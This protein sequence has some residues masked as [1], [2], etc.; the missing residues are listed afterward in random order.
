MYF[1]L[2]LKF[3]ISYYYL[4]WTSVLW[5]LPDSF[6]PMV[7]TLLSLCFILVHVQFRLKTPCLTVRHPKISSFWGI[8]PLNSFVGNVH[9]PLSW[10]KTSTHFDTT[11]FSSSPPSPAMTLPPYLSP[12]LFS[13]PTTLNLPRDSSDFWPHFYHTRPPI[14]T[15]RPFSALLVP[16]IYKST[17]SNSLHNG[18]KDTWSEILVT[19]SIRIES[20]KKGNWRIMSNHKTLDVDSLQLEN[21]CIGKEG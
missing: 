15:S 8:P 13:F 5:L 6:I 11:L 9:L 1:W 2:V 19:L 21:L 12:H 3:S 7:R 16:Y 18:E 14:T 20:A 4:S 10:F 17:S